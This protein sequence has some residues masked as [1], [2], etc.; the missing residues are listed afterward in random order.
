MIVKSIQLKNFRNYKDQI[1]NLDPG[2]NVLV[3]DN[4]EG[5]TNML[6]S[7]YFCANFSSPRTTNDKEMIRFNQDHAIVKLVIKKKYRDNSIKIKIDSHKKKYVLVDDIPINRVAELMGVLGVVFFSPQEIKLIQESPD[8]R[9]KFLN[10]AL[11]QQ[12]KTYF[13]ALNDYRKILANKNNLL[14]KGLTTDQVD[15]MLDVYDAQLAKEGEFIINKRMSFL[16]VL[17]N[18]SNRANEKLSESEE[19]LSLEY[20]TNISLEGNIQTNLYDSLVKAR[21]KDKQLGYTS[22]GPHRDD[23]K[24]ILN[25]NDARKFASQ[26]QQRSITLAM[27]LASLYI[28]RNETGEFP[29]LLLD[30]VL[31]E[32]DL[33]RQKILLDMLKDIQIIL[34]C[35]HYNIDVP[36]KIINIK[37]GKVV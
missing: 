14:K 30:D 7:I 29:V 22:V 35:T 26:G 28:Y 4:A 11:S 5:K 32:L 33:K 15:T 20:E 34:T 13:R 16:N 17:S 6:E 9:R 18:Y 12:D 36:A 27:K 8:D 10:I 19:T 37:D 3:G 25:G 21:E 24:I 23:I 31:S 1:L 2:L